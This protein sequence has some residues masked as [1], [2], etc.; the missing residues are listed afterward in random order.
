SPA[1]RARSGAAAATAPERA[2]C[3]GESPHPRDV[4]GGGRLVACH[5][6]LPPTPATPH[7]GPAGGVPVPAEEA[8]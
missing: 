6:P 5:L 7:S 3:A 4:P 8:R 1:Q 2:R